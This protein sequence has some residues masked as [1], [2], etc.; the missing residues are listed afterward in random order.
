MSDSWLDCNSSVK[1]LGECTI[2]G[3]WV[4]MRYIGPSRGYVWDRH[5]NFLRHVEHYLSD[6]RLD[7]SRSH[8]TINGRKVKGSKWRRWFNGKR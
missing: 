4:P 1:V 2:E 6:G 8:Y 5:G 3:H 7:H